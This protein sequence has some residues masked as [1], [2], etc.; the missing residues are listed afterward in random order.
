[1]ATFFSQNC[2]DVLLARCFEQHRKG[3]YVDVGAESPVQGSVTNYFYELG[4]RGINIEP[5]PY[6]F[7]QLQRLRPRDLN[8]NIAA[9]NTDGDLISI[10]VVQ[11]TGLSSV[12]PQRKELLRRQGSHQVESLEISTRTLNKILEW[13]QLPWIDFLKIDVEGH[14]LSVLQGLN[15]S[16]FRPKIILV[17]TTN[18]LIY[19]GGRVPL[20][21]RPSLAQD[22]GNISNLIAT[23][24]Y[25][26]IYFDGLNTWWIDQLLPAKEYNHFISA[27]STPVNVFDGI[28]PMEA[29][30]VEMLLYR[31]I[32]M[33]ARA[34]QADCQAL[35]R[36]YQLVAETKAL[37]I[38]QE[39]RFNQ[40]LVEKEAQIDTVQAKLSDAQLQVQAIEGST[41]WKITK[42]Y[43][44]LGEQLRKL[45]WQESG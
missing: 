40:L 16:L 42:P 34:R 3:Y 9:S 14:E 29:G 5:V 4:W 31:R 24:N 8:F 26:N 1:M 36:Q 2:E 27:F 11:E 35:H 7:N 43:R 13:A 23:A 20:E 15:F 25:K 33:L 21:N 32:D 18:P 10:D 30:R 12:D 38:E 22:Y 45:R 19:D 37:L 17:E 41:S 44:Q 39:A 28:S 6:Y